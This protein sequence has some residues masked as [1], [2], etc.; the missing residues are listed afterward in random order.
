MNPPRPRYP[1]INCSVPGCKRGT[2]WHEP[3][4][5]IICGQCWRR[6]PKAV[7]EEYSRWRRKGNALDKRGDPRADLC[8]RRAS[9]AWWKIRRLLS[10]QPSHSAELAALVA[11][12]LRKAG[13]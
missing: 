7:R 11:E 12:E 5:L 13:L 4:D 9:R 2:T 10:D 3:G 8:H 1:R 6:A